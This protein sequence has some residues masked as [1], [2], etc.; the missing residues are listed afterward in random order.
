MYVLI[1]SAFVPHYA[2]STETPIK[3]RA[4]TAAG[5]Q[6]PKHLFVFQVPANLMAF[7]DE[8]WPHLR[9]SGASYVV[10]VSEA[11]PSKA[12]ADEIFSHGH[13]NKVLHAALFLPLHD[14]DEFIFY[15][16]TPCDNEKAIIGGVWTSK[17]GLG[18]YPLFDMH[19]LKDL[20]CRH[21]KVIRGVHRRKVAGL[22]LK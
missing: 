19:L 8:Y 9:R 20:S 15:H 4:L 12:T 2:F 18:T 21:I 22:S 1:V 13:M 3:G 16:K 11:M 6:C 5:K 14:S 10:V 7:L 17:A